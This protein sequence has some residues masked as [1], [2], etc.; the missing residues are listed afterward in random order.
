MDW[1]QSSNCT[2]FYCVLK[3]LLGPEIM[4]QAELNPIYEWEAT[5]RCDQEDIFVTETEVY[6]LETMVLSKA[7]AIIEAELGDNILISL[8]RL[9]V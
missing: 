1:T 9:D 7:A 2:K 6:F 5:W 4:Q 8:K 3:N